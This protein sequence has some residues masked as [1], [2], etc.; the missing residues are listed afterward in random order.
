MR[1]ESLT[2]WFVLLSGPLRAQETLP[3]GSDMSE[4]MQELAQR[5][6]RWDPSMI[7]P[8]DSGDLIRPVRSI[9]AAVIFLGYDDLTPTTE[10]ALHSFLDSA[11]IELWQDGKPTLLHGCH[12]IQ[13]PEELAAEE[14]RGGFRYVCVPIGYPNTRRSGNGIEVFNHRMRLLLNASSL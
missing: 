3:W 2:I 11:A 12:Y 6:M 13:H 4:R 9:E 7:L 8:T 1:I 14:K 10:A 5:D